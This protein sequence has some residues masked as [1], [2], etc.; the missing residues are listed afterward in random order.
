[1]DKDKRVI[2]S[3]SLTIT[4]DSVVIQGIYFVGVLTINGS[5]IKMMNNYFAEA[6]FVSGNNNLLQGNVFAGFYSCCGG[7]MVMFSSGN[8]QNNLIVNNYFVT[9]RTSGTLSGT[10]FNF[11]YGGNSSN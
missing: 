9:A 2:A 5:N 11:I 3:S 4:K 1:I 6:V 7:G 8:P 10:S